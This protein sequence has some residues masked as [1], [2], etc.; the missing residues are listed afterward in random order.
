MTSWQSSNVTAGQYCCPAIQLSFRNLHTSAWALVH[1]IWHISKPIYL[2]TTLPSHS[3]TCGSLSIW[4]PTQRP[5]RSCQLEMQSV[6]TFVEDIP[7]ETPSPLCSLVIVRIPVQNWDN[8]GRL[9]F[10]LP[11]HPLTFYTFGLLCIFDTNCQIIQIW[12]NRKFGK[13]GSWILEIESLPIVVYSCVVTQACITYH[14][15]INFAFCNILQLISLSSEFCWTL[16]YWASDW[17]GGV[18]QIGQQEVQR[19]PSAL[20]ASTHSHLPVFYEPSSLLMI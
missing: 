12:S 20:P 4:R 7:S 3:L 13:R 6:E 17:D 5:R 10:R 11:M 16:I 18:W 19:R 2:A 8:G 9:P 15:F 14:I 1:I